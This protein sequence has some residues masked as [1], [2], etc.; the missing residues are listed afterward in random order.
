MT[1]N[2]VFHDY[3]TNEDM[4]LDY[5][6]HSMCFYITQTELYLVNQSVS[7]DLPKMATIFTAIKTH[8]VCQFIGLKHHWITLKQLLS[9]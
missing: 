7:K 4:N 2:Q 5:L 6:I 8:F 3:G 9:Q 1:L